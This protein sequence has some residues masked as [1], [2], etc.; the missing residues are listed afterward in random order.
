MRNPLN[1]TP[2]HLPGVAIVVVNHRRAHYHH[3]CAAAF[4]QGHLVLLA[5]V[6]ECCYLL[7]HL[8]KPL[9]GHRR[10]IDQLQELRVMACVVGLC[11]RRVVDKINKN[12]NRTHR[13]PIIISF[14]IV[15]ASPWKMTQPKC[16]AYRSAQPARWLLHISSKIVSFFLINN[17]GNVLI[18][19]RR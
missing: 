15:K 16:C 11:C 19:M 14:L 4:E 13:W 8:D 3:F 18:A 10:Q 12:R 7:G 9:D 5:H 1:V 2:T 6:T 17:T